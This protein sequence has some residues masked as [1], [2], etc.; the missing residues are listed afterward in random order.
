[1]FKTRRYQFYEDNQ[2]KMANLK[3]TEHPN[4]NAKNITWCQ[5]MGNVTHILKMFKNVKNK[6]MMRALTL[7]SV[8][9]DTLYKVTAL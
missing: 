5:L 1:M 3:L 6:V 2:P 9:M 7:K 4:I 8:F